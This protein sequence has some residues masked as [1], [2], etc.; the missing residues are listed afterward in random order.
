MFYLGF[1][2]FFKNHGHLSAN[3]KNVLVSFILY[4]SS[5]NQE[6]KHWVWDTKEA[7]NIQLLDWAP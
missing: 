7:Y 2:W 6:R 5:E 3:H 4:C 1:E